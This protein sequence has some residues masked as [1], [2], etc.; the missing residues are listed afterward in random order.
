MLKY[1]EGF[2]DCVGSPQSGSGVVIEA[3]YGVLL[4]SL[5]QLDDDGNKVIVDWNE[6][7]T[8]F[9]IDVNRPVY[10]GSL[11]DNYDSNF[12][13]KNNDVSSNLYNDIVNLGFKPYSDKYIRNDEAL[14]SFVIDADEDSVLPISYNKDLDFC[15]FSADVRALCLPKVNFYIYDEFDRDGNLLP[16][17]VDGDFGIKRGGYEMTGRCTV[18]NNTEYTGAIDKY[19]NNITRN[20]VSVLMLPVHNDNSSKFELFG[21]SNGVSG[22]DYDIKIEEYSFDSSV[23]YGEEVNANGVYG[24]VNVNF[25]NE[26][27]N[28]ADLV[29]IYS[30]QF[31]GTIGSVNNG[32]IIPVPFG[33]SW[34]NKLNDKIYCNL[35]YN[36][37]IV[38]TLKEYK[39]LSYI[40]T[41]LDNGIYNTRFKY[42]SLFNGGES[43]YLYNT[44]NQRDIS[45]SDTIELGVKRLPV[46][47]FR[48]LKSDFD[49]NRPYIYAINNTI[50]PDGYGVLLCEYN[51]LES[52]TDLILQVASNYS[53][54]TNLAEDT[55]FTI[56]C[57][58]TKPNEDY[59]CSITDRNVL[60][61][62]KLICL[63][64]EMNEDVQYTI[65]KL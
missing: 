24:L 19:G 16:Q 7:D 4:T 36:L 6:E 48:I 15:S 9:V 52:E 1:L 31:I 22:S 50:G 17:F 12:V 40:R 64:T 21:K 13:H 60:K 28:H 65:R 37:G 61:V 41:A 14:M 2:F 35:N 18:T 5:Y 29:P 3:V 54:Y 53:S 47:N 33:N 10:V 30:C 11:R 51:D 25:V 49:L 45:I 8:K 42:T 20:K 59:L 32:E 44:S 63:Q 38:P 43:V 46:I 55:N 34:G 26:D 57:T 39:S 58:S 27:S 62:Y 56:F 23:N